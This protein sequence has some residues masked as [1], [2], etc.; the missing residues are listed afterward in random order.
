M[1]E[2][3]GEKHLRRDIFKWFKQLKERQKQS[4]RSYKVEDFVRY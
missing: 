4:F 1:M 3:F 2:I